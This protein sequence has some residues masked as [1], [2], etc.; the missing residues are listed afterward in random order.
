[1]KK[2]L[3]LLTLAA[4]LIWVP[5]AFAL[6]YDYTVATAKSVDEVVD[7]VTARAQADGFK[8]PGVHTLPSPDPFVLVELCDPVEAKK[9]MAV[10]MKLGLL[11]PCGKIGVYKD[12]KD[13]GKTKISLLLPL[14]M[15]RIHPAK[16]VAA[17]A[18]NL[19]PRL[20]KIVDAVK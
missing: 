13:G 1:V 15:S 19:D 6:D 9:V 16:E 20:R 11:L 5:A 14:S 12:V 4:F 2:W 18:G 17:M 7:L 8:V 3:L 10:D